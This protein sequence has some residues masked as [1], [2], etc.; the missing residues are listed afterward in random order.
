MQGL[1]LGAR[2]DDRQPLTPLGADYVVE[3]ARFTAEDLLVQEEHGGERLVL[4]RRAHMPVDRQRCEE[5]RD[6]RRPHLRRMPFV[7][8][9]DEPPSPTDV[10]F[11]GT[12]AVVA[13]AKR[14]AHLIKELPLAR[15]ARVEW[16]PQLGAPSSGLHR[17][18]PVCIR[19]RLPHCLLVTHTCL[20]LSLAK[21]QRST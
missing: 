4:R 18:A 9:Q 2:Q 10:R 16:R 7:V 13:C 11:L 6:L 14:I 17:W 8:K 5:L 12:V 21:I 15:S 3:P 20:H 1:H 19:G